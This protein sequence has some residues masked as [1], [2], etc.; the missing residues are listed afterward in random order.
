ME[1]AALAD[2]DFHI[3]SNLVGKGGVEPPL[4]SGN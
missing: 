2:D 3:S 4:P 1:K